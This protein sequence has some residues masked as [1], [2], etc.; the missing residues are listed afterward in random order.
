[1]RRTPFIALSILCTGTVAGNT[2]TT[3]MTSGTSLTDDDDDDDTTA[4]E[5][6]R[7]MRKD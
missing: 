3:G 6:R 5:S 2:S 1:M 7:R 4:T